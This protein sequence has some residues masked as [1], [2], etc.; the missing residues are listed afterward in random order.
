[1]TVKDGSIFLDANVLLYYLDGSSPHHKATEDTLR[2]FVE[3][4]TALCTSHHALEEV[5]HV[6]LQ[7]YNAEAATAALE[8]IANIPGLSLVEPLADFAFAQRYTKL[9]ESVNVG[10]N[11]CL[12]LQLILDNGIHTLYSYDQALSRAATALNIRSIT[13]N[14]KSPL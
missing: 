8:D 6:T 12:I 3:S 2:Q 11:D 13:N 5:L 14:T 7:V 1:M 4:G 9:L 10:L